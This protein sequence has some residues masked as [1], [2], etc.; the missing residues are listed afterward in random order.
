M[1]QERWRI[2]KKGELRLT[3]ANLEGK[4]SFRNVKFDRHGRSSFLF[5]MEFLGHYR[6]F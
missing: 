5:R 3:E 1:P 6:P 4:V 2:P